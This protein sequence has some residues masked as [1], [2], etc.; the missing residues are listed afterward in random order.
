MVFPDPKLIEQQMGNG[1]SETMMP[2][3]Q[4]LMAA[5]KMVAHKHL[6]GSRILGSFLKE[7]R[8]Y[9]VDGTPRLPS[10]E[11]SD[12]QAPVTDLA[13]IDHL[14][15]PPKGKKSSMPKVAQPRIATLPSR[16][17]IPIP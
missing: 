5:V 7:L 2:R 13:E 6:Q 15:T 11:G 17:N 12:T 9:T 4:F 16:Y 14:L 10:S 8:L 1:L 3:Y